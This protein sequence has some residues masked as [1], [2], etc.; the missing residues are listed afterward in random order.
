[1]IHASYYYRIY[2]SDFYSFVLCV[3]LSQTVISLRV[4]FITSLSLVFPNLASHLDPNKHSI[5]ICSTELN[6]CPS[7]GMASDWPKR[8]EW[9]HESEIRKDT[10]QNGPLA[11]WSNWWLPV[12]DFW[13]MAQKEW[14]RWAN[15]LNFR[16]EQYIGCLTQ[17]LPRSGASEKWE[18]YE[19]RCQNI[20]KQES[21][22]GQKLT[23]SLCMG[24]SPSQGCQ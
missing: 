16:C 11:W 15:F 5:S 19:G 24:K 22:E 14:P 9:Q 6:F 3:H 4:G 10:N 20:D 18:H 17:T 8:Q 1:M 2:H 7:L 21:T 13:P 12:K 23:Y